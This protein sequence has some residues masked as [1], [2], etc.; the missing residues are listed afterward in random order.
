[1]RAAKEDR[2]VDVDDRGASHAS[3]ASTEPM[4]GSTISDGDRRSGSTARTLWPS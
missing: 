4:D 1:M 2:V 3:L